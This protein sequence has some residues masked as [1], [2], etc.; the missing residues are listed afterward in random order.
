MSCILQLN[1]CSEELLDTICDNLELKLETERGG[2]EVFE[3]YRE[4]GNQLFVP[5]SYSKTV[6]SNIWYKKKVVYIKLPTDLRFT[7]KLRDYQVPVKKEALN[8]LKAD[9]TV[10]LSMYCGWGKTL[11]GIYLA[12]RCRLKTLI[13]IH[14]VILME[15][16]R[17]SILTFLPNATIQ[18][19]GNRDCILQDCDFYIINPINLYKYNPDT[20]SQVG[21][22]IVDEC[23]LITSKIFSQSLWNV[24]P[25]YSIGLSATPYRLDGLNAAIELFFGKQIVRTLNHPHIVH[26]LY[27]RLTPIVEYNKMGKIDWN[28]IINQQAECPERNQLIVNIVTT[29]STEDTY[30]LILCKRVNQVKELVKICTS[31]NISVTSLCGSNNTYDKKAKVLIGTVSKL[32]VGFDD[33]RL[34]VLIL[35]CDIKNYFI[36]VLARIMRQPDTVPIIFDIIDN[37]SILKNHYN[38]RKKIYFNHGGIIECLPYFNNTF[39]YNK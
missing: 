4:R 9:K 21:T 33:K 36:Q 25:K 30:F 1:K 39:L 15:Q 20:L 24:Q 2:E 26:P 17:Q 34:N 3:C 5:L 8:I 31:H 18:I 27:T 16:W 10:L 32:S 22:V 12:W 13:V 19:L 23:H 11:M 29:F 35:A 14:R 37:N 28:S 38:A 7:A 6:C